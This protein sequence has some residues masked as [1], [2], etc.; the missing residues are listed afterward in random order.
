MIRKLLYLLPF[1]FIGCTSGVTMKSVRYDD[2]FNDS[3]SKVWLV[4][5][6]VVND[7]NIASSA[8]YSKDILIFFDNGMV[9]LIS[10]K[11]LG[12]TSPERGNYYLDSED[13]NM[14]IEFDET[15]WN[16]NLDYLTEDSVMFVTTKDSDKQFT[17]QIIPLTEL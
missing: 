7:V 6:Y 13:R 9:N 3:N 8:L 15:S 17:M 4:N 1:I 5:E 14:V 10:M 11:G 2:L 16:M 12:V